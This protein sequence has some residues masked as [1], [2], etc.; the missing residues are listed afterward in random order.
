MAK[1]LREINNRI[2]SVKSTAQITRAMQ[3]VAAS[4]MKRAQDTALSGR[5]YGYLLADILDSTLSCIGENDYAH[6]FLHYREV[7]TRG[8]LLVTTDK[9][10][11]GALN[12]N[13]YRLLADIPKTAKFVAVG[14]KGAQ[15]LARIGRTL[16]AE[17]PVS[18]RVEF[19]EIRI[20][21]EYLKNQYLDGAVDTIEILHSRFKNTLVQEAVLQPVLPLANIHAMVEMTRARLGGNIASAG[22]DEREMTFEPSVAEILDQLPFLFLRNTLYRALL[23]AKAS[24]HSARMVAMKS[25]TDNAQKIT[26][27][28][29][30]EYNKARQASITQEINEITAASLMR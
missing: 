16:L 24:E 13:L 11:C 21:G 14:R 15:Y 23:E 27:S 10:L 18:D 19:S 4:K 8:I 7:K 6:P 25:A 9:G 22:R 1:G 29:T 30:L 12:A 2:K 5:D 3:L 17:F 20:I 28:L 26:E